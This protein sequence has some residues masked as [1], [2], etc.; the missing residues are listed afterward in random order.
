MDNLFSGV[1]IGLVML[2]AGVAIIFAG[3]AL[4][5]PLTWFA[6][7]GTMPL[8]FGLPTIGYWTAFKLNLLASLLIKSTQTTSSK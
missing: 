5:A 2:V 3:A 8:L 6:W 1:L 4:V 7:N